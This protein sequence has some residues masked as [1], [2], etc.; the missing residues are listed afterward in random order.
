MNASQD[1]SESREKSREER[2]QEPRNR[3]DEVAGEVEAEMLREAEDAVKADIEAAGSDMEAAGEEPG[4]WPPPLM[5]KRSK[6]EE[7]EA[8]FAFTQRLAQQL[9]PGPAADPVPEPPHSVI[10]DETDDAGET[11]K[12]DV[13][14]ARDDTSSV[15][16]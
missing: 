10:E 5:P 15:R 11:D 1:P 2:G 8:F 16:E 4:D 13:T 12:T 9:N 6:R 3:A 14:G 7:A